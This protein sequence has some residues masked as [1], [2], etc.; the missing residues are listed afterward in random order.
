M[1]A[2]IAGDDG[3]GASVRAGL[4]ELALAQCPA[5]RTYWQNMG[6][7][8]GVPDAAFRNDSIYWFPE[9]PPARVFRTSGTSG[10]NRGSAYYSARGLELMD[11]SILRSARLFTFAHLDRPVV[12]RLVPDERDA[13]EMIM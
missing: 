12:M 11:A 3:R 7:E 1:G 9:Q 4:N 6:G 13:P 2:L 8:V 10:P 5:L